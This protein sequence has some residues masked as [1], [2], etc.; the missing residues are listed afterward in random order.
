[1]RKYFSKIILKPIINLYCNKV[2][3][4]DFKNV[5]EYYNS[6]EKK[7]WIAINEEDDSLL[8]VVA[9]DTE[10]SLIQTYDLSKYV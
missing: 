4:T 8:G 10:P 5:S 7:C 9:Y 6:N 2:F 1:M 3:K